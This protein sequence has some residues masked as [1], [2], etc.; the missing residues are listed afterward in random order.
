MIPE[1]IEEL[2]IELTKA[3]PH[4]FD[5]DLLRVKVNGAS[6]DVRQARKYPASYSEAMIEDDMLNYYSTVLAVAR[7]DYNILG[8]EGQKSYHED[9]VTVHYTDRDKLFYGVLPIAK[10]V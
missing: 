1:I 2:T 10:K 9:G 5:A 3:D 4:L 7:Y 8:A 6:R